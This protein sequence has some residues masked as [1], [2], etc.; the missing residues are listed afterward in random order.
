MNLMKGTRNS[1][2]P[3]LIAAG[4]LLASCAGPSSSAAT[5]STNQQGPAEARTVQVSASGSVQ[6][7]PDT[8]LLRLGVETLDPRAQS[9]I[10]NNRRRMQSVQ[11]ALADQGIA[12]VDIQTVQFRVD[13]EQVRPDIADAEATTRFRVTHILQVQTDQVA[14]AGEL[15]QAALDAGANRV[16]SVQFSIADPTALESQA[17]SQA[18]AAARAKAD[19]LANGLGAEVGTV[20]QII[21]SG[22][23]APRPVMAAAAESPAAMPIAS[24]SLTVTVTVDVTFDLKPAASQDTNK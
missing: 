5:D 16:Q 15:L 8:A 11:S 22:A 10:D 3:I 2:L 7:E 20:R 17:R 6:A 12:A 19:E 9:A 23:G 1:I 4:L 24:G 21:E 13:V 14:S 18:V